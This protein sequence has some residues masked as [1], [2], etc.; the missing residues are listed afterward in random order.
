MSTKDY[1]EFTKEEAEGLGAFHEDALDIEDVESD[2][3]DKE[4][5]LR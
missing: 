1:I 3:E 2:N 5:T 4:N